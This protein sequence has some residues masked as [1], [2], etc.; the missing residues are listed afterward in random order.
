MTSACT[1]FGALPLFLASGAGAESLRPIGIV[2]VFGV[3]I[4]AV[5]TMFAVPALYAVLARGT[6]SPHYVARLIARLRQGEGTRAVPPDGIPE[7]ARE[8]AVS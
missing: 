4:S 6:R 7:P 5:L 1:T 2:V 3:T 8:T